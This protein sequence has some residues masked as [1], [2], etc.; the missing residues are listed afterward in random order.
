MKAFH[1]Q[2]KENSWDEACHQI[3]F[4]DSRAQAKYNSEAHSNGVPWTDILAKRK[5]QFDQYAETK[6]VPKSEYVADGWV[7]EC[8]KCYS[9]SATNVKDNKVLCDDCCEVIE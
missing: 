6:V 4:A 8:D 5:P 3:V 9:F 1:V 7:F 2:D